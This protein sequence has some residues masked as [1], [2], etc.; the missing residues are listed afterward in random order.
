MT[1]TSKEMHNSRTESPGQSKVGSARKKNRSRSASASSVE[2]VSSGSYTGSSSEE[3]E[4][5]PRENIQ[6]NSSGNSDFCVKK[7]GQHS[8]GRREIEIAEQEMPGIMAL[9]HKAK[10]DK[11]L[12]GAKIVVCTH[13]N[14]QTAV[15]V[16]TLVTLGAQVRWA[17][18]NIYS[19]QNEVAAALAEAG[20]PVFAWRGESEEDFWWCIDQCI[21]AENWQPNMVLD[22]GGDATHL[23]V[24]K[25]NSI[26][27]L[28]KGIVEESITGVHRLYQVSQTGKLL[29]PAMNV[30]DSVIK[31]KYDNLYAC[32]ESI[33][34]S[35]KRTTDIM[36]GGKQVVVCGYGQV[37]KGC[38]QSLKAMGCIVYVTEI[39]PICALQACMDGFQVVKLTEVVQKVDIVITATGNKNVVTRDNMD[40]M[41]NGCIVCNMDKMKN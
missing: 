39:D 6:K 26:F 7:I 1:M 33:I 13:I 11:P 3:D 35:L 38:A 17:A 22:D 9:R 37:G 15:M 16:E 32:R 29:C 30:N 21:Q 27:K 31:T 18:C 19:T 24:K 4:A 14:A 34:D 5:S 28:M 8:Y 20:V 10:E 12:K 40:K 41:K 23:L 25:Y 36:F 2:S